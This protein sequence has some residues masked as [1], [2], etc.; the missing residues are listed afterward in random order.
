MD[1]R[2]TTLAIPVLCMLVG[3]FG[4]SGAQAETGMGLVIDR[5]TLKARRIDLDNGEVVYTS[6]PFGSR[7]LNGRFSPDGTRI[8][9]INE[10][11]KVQIW[12]LQGN[13][14]KSF[15]AF[16]GEEGSV[17]WT[18]I[19]GEDRIWVG[20]I[21]KLVRY[22]TEGSA[23]ETVTLKGGG[24]G[25]TTMSDAE[26]QET[27]AKAV[28]H[29][30]K[31]AGGRP[32]FA[33]AILLDQRD[34]TNRAPVIKLGGGCSVVPSPDG[35]RLTRNLWEDE[36]DN[37]HQT[38]R[39][40][41]RDGKSLEYFYIYDILKAYAPD[42][43]DNPLHGD[44]NGYTW[45]TQSWS[46]NSNDIILIPAGRC[47]PQMFTDKGESRKCST[48]PW[49]YNLRTKKAFCLYYD[50]DAKK[51]NPYKDNVW[52]YIYDFYAGTIAA[53]PAK[54]CDDPGDC[55]DD[56]VCT[57][58]SCD[59]DLCRNE[60][61]AGCCVGAEECE[62][63]DE[64]TADS[65]D[66]HE[67]N[68]APIEGCEAASLI[69]ILAPTGGETFAVGE[70]VHVRWSTVDIEEVVLYL[71]T[72][73]GQTWDTLGHVDNTE[74]RWG[75][76]SW[77]ITEETVSPSCMVRIESYFGAAPTR[78][79]TFAVTEDGLSTDRKQQPGGSFSLGG[80]CTLSSAALWPQRTTGTLFLAGLCVWYVRRRRRRARPH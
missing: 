30:E 4:I 58:D 62:D 71:S 5:A 25:S 18:E 16:I 49:I 37:E 45:N 12:N 35:S 73:G 56:N 36:D 27:R 23:L 57:T 60:A 41:G 29:N 6:P 9:T 17:S 33:A 52:W 15:D 8:V 43:P 61:I 72:D 54:S 24:S 14:M 7:L 38:M 3:V 65:C 40:H 47:Y 10:G 32:K 68:H 63:G 53:R 1:L 55:D 51:V 79:G 19:D 64:C 26:A 20:G 31:T 75:D 66:S 34:S 46:S 13:V 42:N 50:A 21:G 48:M 28:S 74:P 11:K 67:C 69:E 59:D 39:I 22:D 80:G 76:F 78:S 2:A 44:E 70:A 77:T